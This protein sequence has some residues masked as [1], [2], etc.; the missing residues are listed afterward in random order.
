M[1]RRKAHRGLDP[2]GHPQHFGGG[3]GVD[4]DPGQLGCLAAFDLACT[5]LRASQAACISRHYLLT[6]SSRA[7]QSV[8]AGLRLPWSGHEQGTRGKCRSSSICETVMLL[9]VDERSKLATLSVRNASK[10]HSTLKRVKSMRPFLPSPPPPPRPVHQHRTSQHGQQ[11]S[12]AHPTC[13]KSS[14][15]QGRE[16]ASAPSRPRGTPA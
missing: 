15:L 13:R 5:A 9:R 2:T 1:T 16:A 6:V 14:S 8:A 11:A 4:Q 10:P 12:S 7:V 3:R